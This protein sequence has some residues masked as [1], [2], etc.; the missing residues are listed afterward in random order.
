MT[1]NADVIRTQIG[2][3]YLSA[4]YISPH[5]HHRDVDHSIK[6]H[7]LSLRTSRNYRRTDPVSPAS[8]E[9]IAGFAATYAPIITTS[10]SAKMPNPHQV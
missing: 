6:R 9:R 5:E 7:A 3:S 8:E 4:N 1:T 10:D 2:R